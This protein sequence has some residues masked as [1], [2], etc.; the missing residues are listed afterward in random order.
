VAGPASSLPRSLLRPGER[1]IWEGRPVARR[2]ILR[3]SLLV[4]PFTLLW[5]AFAVFWEVS[6]LANRTP[7]F[8]PLWGAAFVAFG[9]YIA[10]GRF[11]V[12]W[13]EARRTA[14]LLT[15]Q[16]IVIVSGAF[17]QRLRELSLRTLPAPALDRGVDGIGTITFGPLSPFESW[18]PAGWP[19]MSGSSP[20]FVAIEDA[21][22]VFDLVDEAVAEARSST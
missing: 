5:L 6:A 15:N 22:H 8:F 4:I 3:G 18:L 12:A 19:M 7:S 9:L 2:F 1:I 11:Y 13:R 21:S 14:Y 10:F 16:R 17:A 20:S